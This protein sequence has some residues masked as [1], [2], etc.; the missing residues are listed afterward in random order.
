[1][2]VI[3]QIH[4]RR[5]AAELIGIVAAAT[6]ALAVVIYGLGYFFIYNLSDPAATVGTAVGV[7]E[8]GGNLKISLG[9]SCPAGVTYTL[10]FDRDNESPDQTKATT[11]VFTANT[12]LLEFDP[13][14]LPP[15]AVVDTPA[16]TGFQWQDAIRLD[17]WVKYADGAYGY[18]AA[19]SLLDIGE[20]NGHPSGTYLF[21]P[22]WLTPDQMAADDHLVGVCS[23]K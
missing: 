4:K 21:G 7:R 5:S 19:Q 22:D 9:V 20:S 3:L 12:A 2:G 16:P 17:V 18:S 10:V 6:V 15:G 1:M 11:I 14:K 13:F 8:D 23:P